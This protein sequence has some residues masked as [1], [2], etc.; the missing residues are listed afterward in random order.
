MTWEEKAGFRQDRRRRVRELRQRGATTKQIAQTFAHDYNESPLK[1]FRWAH[2]WTLAE[3]CERFNNDVADDPAHG[4]MSPSRLSLYENWPRSANPECRPPGIPLLHEF[5]KLYQCAPGDLI[6][7]TEYT[8]DAEQPAEAAAAEAPPVQDAGD[9]EQAT[10]APPT[11][12]RVL[13]TRRHWRPFEA[14]RTQYERAARELAERDQDPRLGRLSVGKRQFDRWLAGGLKTMPDRDHC[15]VLE[16]LF[17]HPVEQ[18]LAQAPQEP[19]RAQ[20]DASTASSAVAVRED[21]PA[22]QWSMQDAALAEAVMSAR[23]RA[24]R[25][26]AQLRQRVKLSQHDLANRVGYT[27]AHVAGVEAGTNATAAEF[28]RACD[29]VLGTGGV[30]LA[31]R[32]RIEAAQ[33]ARRDAAIRR[34]EATREARLQRWRQ[35]HGLPGGESAL[36][37]ESHAGWVGSSERE[38]DLDAGPRQ[39]HEISVSSDWPGLVS[40]P[41][42]LR[43]RS[44]VTAAE[45][46]AVKEI[47][48]TFRRLDNKFGGLHT[49][50]LVT[51]YLDENVASMLRTGTYTDEIGQELFGAAA[52]LA[53]LAGWTAYDMNRH[54]LAERYFVRALEFATA[55]GDHAF[56]GEVLAARGH[57]AVHMGHPAEAVELARASQHISKKAGIPALL[58]EAHALEAISYALLGDTKASIL[59]VAKS[60][61]AFERSTLEELPEWLT[62][63]DE[64]YIAA[65][66]AH[67]FRDLREWSTARGYALRAVNMTDSLT[68]TRAFNTA[69]LA[70]AYIETDLDQACSV[71]IDAL[72]LAMDLQS[73]RAVQYVGD[74]RRRLIKRYGKDP[75]VTAFTEQSDEMLGAGQ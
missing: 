5:A 75:L 14:F 29:T 16:Y 54:S 62:Y 11:L 74:F 10:A 66:F 58:A 71:G 15:R 25:E 21:L 3:A 60:E 36:Q 41:S 48:L 44:S 46:E 56:C 45:I 35:A 19:D 50:T 64:A 49:H 34:E 38:D 51:H 4:A 53:H 33:K 6:E 57:H 27:R 20:V 17:G 69:M 18:L 61:R 8:A 23:K 9:D 73:I 47:T 7:G 68:R 37:E 65:R 70:T 67:C 42:D 30:L 59:A 28:W 43:L 24:G 22:E 32:A 40:L 12:L 55:S 72:D 26:L 39:S 1:A 31:A 52:Q 2:D 63:L 13:V